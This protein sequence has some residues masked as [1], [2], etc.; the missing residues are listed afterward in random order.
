MELR[1]G[2]LVFAMRTFHFDTPTIRINNVLFYY[3][4][5]ANLWVTGGLSVEADRGNGGA[6][7]RSRRKSVARLPSRCGPA[8]RRPRESHYGEAFPQR[9]FS[10]KD[11]NAGR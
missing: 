4:R 7:G 3:L 2:Q 11:R 5:S 9:P 8:G 10:E 1:R 6:C